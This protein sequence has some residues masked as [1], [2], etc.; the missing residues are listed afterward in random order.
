MNLTDIIS[1]IILAITL[2]FLSI[3]IAG[4]NIEDDACKECNL[5]YCLNCVHYTSNKPI[6]QCIR[7]F[8]KYLYK[9]L[10]T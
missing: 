8:F 7:T 5:K 6:G 2:L 1:I 10:K 4:K 3:I 9:H